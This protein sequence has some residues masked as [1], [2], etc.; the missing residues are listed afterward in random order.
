MCLLLDLDIQLVQRLDMITRKRDRDQQNILLAQLGEPLDGI[1]RLRPLPCRG[2]DLG[3]PRE[4]VRIREPEFLH[5]GEDGRGD[6]GDVRVS[7]AAQG[8]VM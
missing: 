1:R 8:S 5:D 6:F 2:P 3:L 4:P 7:S